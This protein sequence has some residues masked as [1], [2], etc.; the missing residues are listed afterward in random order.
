MQC[1]QPIYLLG[2]SSVTQCQNTNSNNIT[3]TI[4]FCDML[5]RHQSYTISRTISRKE[6]FH[7]CSQI[8][9]ETKSTR[10][11]SIVTELKSSLWLKDEGSSKQPREINNPY[12]SHQTQQEFIWV[13][14][15][16]VYGCLFVKYNAI[17][18]TKLKTGKQNSFR[19]FPKFKLDLSKDLSS[20]NFRPVL[21][22]ARMKGGMQQVNYSISTV[23]PQPEGALRL[24]L[25]QKTFSPLRPSPEI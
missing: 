19:G 13:E 16:V 4:L 10:L 24:Q 9:L 3:I 20:F 18:E 1:K 21:S 25:R 12:I 2:T 23:P 22:S 11:I 5:T 7:L 17:L 8:Q 6:C 15:Q 14:S